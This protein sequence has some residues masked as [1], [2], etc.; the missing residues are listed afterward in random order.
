MTVAAL[1]LFALY[2]A[3][4]FGLRTW[5]Q[6]RRTG[7]TGFRGVSGRPGSPEWWAGVLFV[8]A[9]V[10]G[11]LGPVMA[12]AGLAPLPLLDATPLQATGAVIT[13]VGIAATYLTQVDMGTNWRI[14]VQAGERTDLVTTGA[15]ALVRNP[16]FT[17]MAITGLGLALMVPNVVALSGVVLLVVALELQVRVVEEPYLLS[18][19][20]ARYAHYT[21][22]TGRFLPGIGRGTSSELTTEEVT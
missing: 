22:G 5:V 18:T 1:A 10:A 17:A 16:I 6:W 21:A 4:A 7:D 8:L 20:G 3:M 13:V 12:L 19:H 15:F 14:G 9:L 11:F 2:L